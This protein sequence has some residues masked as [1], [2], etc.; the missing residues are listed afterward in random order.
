MNSCQW[1]L[2]PRAD[3]LS[4]RVSVQVNVI[5][6]LYQKYVQT[7][8]TYKRRFGVTIRLQISHITDVMF[9]IQK[10]GISSYSN[11]EEDMHS[12]RLD[13]CWLNKYHSFI[14]STLE[15]ED[16]FSFSALILLEKLKQTQFLCLQFKQS[17][18]LK[19]H[20]NAV[21]IMTWP[22][23]GVLLFQWSCPSPQWN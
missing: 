9:D 22:S 21:Q 17:I 7:V 13:L 23:S 8:G 2:E 12:V 3:D 14:Y 1:S 18:A 6:K 15:D 16:K 20:H 4:L 5:R 19:T 11:I 10:K